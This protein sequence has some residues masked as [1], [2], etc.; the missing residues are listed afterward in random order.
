MWSLVSKHKLLLSD[1]DGE[2]LCVVYSISTGGTHLLNEVSGEILHRI[3]RSACTTE[4][5]VDALS[6]VFSFE[7]EVDPAAAIE[8][9]LRQLHSAGLI[10]GAST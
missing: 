4:T 3:N 6:K 1:W 5:L 10:D 2:G 8:A 9:S 7:A